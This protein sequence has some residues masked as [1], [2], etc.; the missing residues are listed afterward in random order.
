MAGALDQQLASG[1]VKETARGM[2]QEQ[3]QEIGTM[4][5]LLDTLGATPLPYP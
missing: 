4:S 2:I 1:P 3:R 5:M